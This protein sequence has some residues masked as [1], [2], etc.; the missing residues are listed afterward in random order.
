MTKRATF[1]SVKHWQEDVSANISSKNKELPTFIM[2]GNKTDLSAERQVTKEEA[3]ALAGS[4]G[5]EYFETS[6]KDNQG[7]NEMMEAL[8][9]A[10]L[11]KHTHPD[12]N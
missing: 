6:A 4:L 5:M 1:D 8:S 9:Q 3:E 2:V 12:D 7:I 10:L 11:Q